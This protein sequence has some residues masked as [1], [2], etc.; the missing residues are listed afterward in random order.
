MNQLGERL[1]FL[2]N[3]NNITANEIIKGY[4]MRCNKFAT[5]LES[6]SVDQVVA[7]SPERLGSLCSD[8]VCK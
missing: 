7:S 3:S 8:D 2:L 1:K 4:R 5:K 6:M